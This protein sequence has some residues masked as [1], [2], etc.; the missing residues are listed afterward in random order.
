M[1]GL[2]L[3]FVRISFSVS[4]SLLLKTSQKLFGEKDYI[5]AHQCLSKFVKIYSK[6]NAIPV[7]LMLLGQINSVLKKVDQAE[8]IFRDLISLEPQGESVPF[9]RIQL[10]RLFIDTFRYKE[11]EMQIR[12]VMHYN[13]KNNVIASRAMMLLGEI[14]LLN[15]FDRRASQH[16]S[17]A[18]QYALASQVMVDWDA[19]ALLGQI[20]Y[21]RGEYYASQLYR[22]QS[23]SFMDYHQFIEHFIAA[24]KWYV[25]A[26]LL[27]E[28]KMGE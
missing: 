11:A 5:Y 7:A 20:S 3:Y 6:S 15:R 10:A 13:E 25:N 1:F 4:E 12:N 22:F 19:S 18:Y 27:D 8:R 28:S 23:A 9:A 17:K 24:H 2:F 21:F 26:I 14:A 16:L